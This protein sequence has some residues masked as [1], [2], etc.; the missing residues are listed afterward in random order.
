MLLGRP[1]L[2]AALVMLVFGIIAWN[3][4]TRKELNPLTGNVERIM[5]DPEQEIAL[6]LQSVPEMMRQFGGEEENPVVRNRVREIG[7]R[8]LAAKERILR[9]RGTDDFDYPFRFHVLNDERT[10]NA[11]ALPG[12]QIFITMALLKRLPNEDAVAGVIGH[13]IGHVLAWHSN[14]QMA[15]N[16]LL[17]TV[18]NSAVVATSDGTASSAQ[19]A[20]LV[21]NVIATRYGREDES[22]SDLIGVQLVLEAGYDPEAMLKVM[23]VLAESME[24]QQRPP[25]ILSTHPFPETR[26]R[27]IR[28]YIAFFR[29]NGTVA[30]WPR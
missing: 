28:E 13:E 24:G 1:R 29:E 19:I 3:A 11:F 21:A 18:V 2:L 5:L 4:Q 30:V 16:S 12:G 8:L 14:R 6:G 22:E 27:Q 10:I 17:R 15:K 9:K 20:N 25:E 7:E 26:A 23:E